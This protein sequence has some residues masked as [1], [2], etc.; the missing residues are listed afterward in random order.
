MASGYMQRWA[1]TL[2]AYDYTIQFKKGKNNANADALS[3]GR[4]R[5]GVQGVWPPLLATHYINIL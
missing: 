2:G 5:G 1:L 3:R 4:S